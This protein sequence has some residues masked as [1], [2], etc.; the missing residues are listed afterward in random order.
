MTESE[1]KELFNKF[2]KRDPNKN[3][4]S[5]HIRKSYDDFLEQIQQCEE[6]RKLISADESYRIAI[7]LPGHMRNMR[8][9]QWLNKNHKLYKFDVFVYTWDN[10]GDKGKETDINDKIDRK[11]IEDKIK[12]I[13]NVVKYDIGNNKKFILKNQ[14]K[15]IT[16]FNWSSPEIFIKSQ[17]YSIYKCYELL[18]KHIEE[19]GTK[20]SMVMKLRT[21]CD[22]K[23]F[24]INEDM[25]NDINNHDVIF[26]PN[27]KCGHDHPDYDNSC[28]ACDIMY[29]KHKL[30]HVH[31]FEH[32]NV[33]CDLW[34]YG[35]VES[36][37]K[38]CSLYFQYDIM[39]E[40]FSQRNI[41][42]LNKVKTGHR[43]DGNVYL[44]DKNPVGHIHTIY[45]YNCSY[46]ERMFPKYLKDYM[47]VGSKHI[48]IDFAR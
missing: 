9:L 35:S 45:Y 26:V 34:A 44:L 31:C 30:K 39:N 5:I 12:K 29:H 8:I 18:E 37:K 21:E 4:I 16:Y 46:P 3:E 41:E 47:L 27:A 24:I 14:D 10:Y 32:T 48:H 7:L 15:S 19:I 13:P 36:M 11:A 28:H 38:Y 25:I 22:I 40:E 6:R 23:K 33:I 43:K 20:Y 1:L 2:L 42:M 17:L